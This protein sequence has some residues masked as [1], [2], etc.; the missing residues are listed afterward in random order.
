MKNDQDKNRISAGNAE[1][2]ETT[3]VKTL[4]GDPKKAI[5]KLSI[6]MIVAMSVQ[7]IYS[8][9]D[10]YWVS[11][12]GADA[13]AAMGFVF[14]FFFI[15]MALSNGIGIGGG[16]AISRRIGA[17]DKVGADNAAVHT[18]IITVLLS[19]LFTIPFY[20]FAPQLFTLAGAGK[21]TE[22]A[23]A[24]ARV[25]FLGSIVIF[26]S[27]V[28]N[29]ILRSEGDSKRAMKAML[30]SAV[31]NII[32]DPIFIYNLNMGIAGAAWATLLSIAISCLMMGNWLFF[33]KD[34]YLTFDFKNFHF[35]KQIIKEIFEVTVPASVQQLSMSL[36]MIFLNFIIVLVSNTD[37]VAVYATGWRIAT[38]ALAPLIGMSTAII[39]VTGAAI[40][41]HDY[42]K[43]KDALSYSTKLGFLIECGIGAFLFIFATQI[44]SLFTQSEGGTHITADLAHFL[45]VMCL[46]YPIA[47]LGFFSSSFFQGAGKGMSAL[48]ATLLRTI[49][50]TPLFAALLAITFN[51]GQEGAWWGMVIGNGIGSLLMYIWAG[52]FLRALLRTEP[53]SRVD[54]ASA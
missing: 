9:I 35:D 15:S 3:G 45:K 47:S 14:P 22:L 36:S 11:G 16:A 50:F 25:I 26:F 17:Q 34:T 51:M 44:V 1:K 27:S 38:I 6:P 21:T 49:V 33:R 54:G 52:Y 5:V 2:M 24:F 37:G 13:L 43:A 20:I 53:A 46:F 39:S 7:T 31:L 42:L 23:V 4:L 10:T 41:A 29:A 18:I 28:A 48:V 8:L 12:L 32:L 19:I 40:G 30:V